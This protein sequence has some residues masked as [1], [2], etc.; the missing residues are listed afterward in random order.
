VAR[1]RVSD[2]SF[3][4]QQASDALGKKDYVSAAA[5][6]QRVIAV[7]PI[8]PEPYVLNGHIFYDNKQWNQALDAYRK[9]LAKGGTTPSLY[10]RIFWCLMNMKNFAEAADFGRRAVEEGN[11][12]PMMHGYVAEALIQLGKQAEAV[13][14]LESALAN[15]PNDMACLHRLE[16]AYISTGEREKA[17]AI[18]R[19]IQEANTALKSAP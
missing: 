15:A 1:W 7:A 16:Q 5:N 17:E 8:K 19:R 10:G 6:V 9:A 13:P 11:G 4:L 14:Y 2:P 3:L 12:L 18:L